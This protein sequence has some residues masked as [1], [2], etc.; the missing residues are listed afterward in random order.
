MSLDKLQ[1]LADKFSVS[2]IDFDFLRKNGYIQQD[3]KVKVLNTGTLTGKLTVNAHAF[4]EK[5]KAAI[6]AAGGTA[7]LISPLTPKSE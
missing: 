6:E 2:T 1:H 5:A 4:S 7:N 3:S